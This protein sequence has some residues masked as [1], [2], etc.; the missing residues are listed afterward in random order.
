[1]QICSR[2]GHIRGVVEKDDTRG[3]VNS[4]NSKDF[5]LQWN[6]CY[7]YLCLLHVLMMDLFL[8]SECW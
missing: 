7:M 1:M 5:M 3:T 8:L 2:F 6:V 4:S